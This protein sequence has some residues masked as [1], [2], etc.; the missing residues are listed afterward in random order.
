MFGQRPLRAAGFLRLP[1]R[2]LDA[3]PLDESDRVGLCDGSAADVSDQGQWFG[4][5]VRDDGVQVDA[6]RRQEVASLERLGASGRG[7]CGCEV[8]RWDQR[9]RCLIMRP[10]TTF[11]NIP[12]NDIIIF[13]EKI[14]AAEA[15][16]GFFV[17]PSFTRD[18]EAQARL[19][20]RMELL[21]ARE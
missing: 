8:R 1:G 15:Q 21:T 3:S 7:D 19:D 16:R 4:F 10:S 5:S 14:K 11:D 20:P 12:K 2:T 17:A 6:K 13:S 9:E 18:A